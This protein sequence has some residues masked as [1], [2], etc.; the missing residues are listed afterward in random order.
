MLGKQPVEGGHACH[1]EHATYGMRQASA[2]RSL[3]AELVQLTALGSVRERAAAVSCRGSRARLADNQVVGRCR[4]TEKH[5]S[6]SN[7]NL[8]SEPAGGA[9]RQWR[10][11]GR[12]HV[13]GVSGVEYLYLYLGGSSCACML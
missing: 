2:V 8:R 1:Y 4:R 5:D 9:A 11:R 6:L 13:P 12:P 7:M 10:W 3:R